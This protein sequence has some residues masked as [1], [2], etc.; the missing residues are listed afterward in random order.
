MEK[1]SVVGP[2]DLVICSEL[3]PHAIGILVVVPCQKLP[4]LNLPITKKVPP[5]IHNKTINTELQPF[6]DRLLDV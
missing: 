4:Q 3:F 2:Y 5:T 6:L 1:R